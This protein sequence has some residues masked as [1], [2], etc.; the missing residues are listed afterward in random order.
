MDGHPTL[1][2][3]ICVWSFEDCS[4]Q[5]ARQLQ[6][7]VFNLCKHKVFPLLKREGKSDIQTCIV[8]WY[9]DAIGCRLWRCLLIY[10]AVCRTIFVLR[11][12]DDDTS[13]PSC[14]PNSLPYSR[15]NCRIQTFQR[16]NSHRRRETRLISTSKL[17]PLSSFETFFF[18]FIYL[19]KLPSG[20]LVSLNLDLLLLQL[21]FFNCFPEKHNF[22]SSWSWIFTVADLSNLEARSTSTYKILWR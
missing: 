5:V 19:F 9:E 1:L 20:N 7:R 4:K 11:D 13:C 16:D 8:L 21:S 10:R 2:L 18:I 14:S 3:P 22:S 17:S 15:S 6:V 12:D